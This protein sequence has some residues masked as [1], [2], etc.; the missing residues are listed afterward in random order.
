MDKLILSELKSTFSNRQ[1][2]ESF[3]RYLTAKQDF[4]M[5]Q[6]LSAKTME[7]VARHQGAYVALEGLKTLREVIIEADKNGNK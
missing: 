4:Y 6:V 7:E 3:N 5:K 1:F 2:V